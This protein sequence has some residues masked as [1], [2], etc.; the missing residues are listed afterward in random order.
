MK[1]AVLLSIFA[2]LVGTLSTAA[3]AAP[4]SFEYSGLEAGSVATGFVEIAASITQST[5][6]ATVSPGNSVAC[7]GDNDSYLR[8]FDLDGEFGIVDPFTVESVDYGVET[9]VSATNV[10]VNLYSIPDG[11]ALTFANL[12]SIGSVTLPAFPDTTA[13]VI[14]TP[15]AGTIADPVATDLVVEVF[16]PDFTGGYTFFIGSN[17]NGQTAPTY[18]SSP[19]CGAPEPTDT[20]LI[21]FPNMHMVMVVNGDVAD[22]TP[23]IEIPTIGQWGLGLLATLLLLGAFF[24]MRRRSATV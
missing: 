9:S 24:L 6:T 8:R 13:A 22:A 2:L 21:G 4:A 10:Q 16:A 7:P 17:A 20:A 12:T 18:L 15:V 5:D 1:R 19:V 11:A 3:I 14:N 23:V